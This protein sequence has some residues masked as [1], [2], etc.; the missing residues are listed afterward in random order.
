MPTIEEQ[1][2]LPGIIL[3]AVQGH[4][5]HKRELADEEH[6]RKINDLIDRHSALISKIP[7]L[8]GTPDYEPALKSLQEVETGLRELYHPAN[9]P[10]AIAKFGHLLTD[11]L[12]I[13]R[14]D[15]TLGTKVSLSDYREG[16]K[17]DKN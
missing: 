15:P 6:G 7:T 4:Y 9:N 5:A 12:G 3:S 1:G 16:K 8:K 14:T 17:Y 10:G 2:G 13:K 11:H